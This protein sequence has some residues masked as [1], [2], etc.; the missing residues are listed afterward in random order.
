MIPSFEHGLIL[1]SKNPEYSRLNF[2]EDSTEFN[3]VFPHLTSSNWAFIPDDGPSECFLGFIKIEILE[4][5]SSWDEK[6]V[7][8][9]PL[10]VFLV[11]NV[12]YRFEVEWAIQISIIFQVDK[13]WFSH[14]VGRLFDELLRN[15]RINKLRRNYNY[16]R[17]G[18][19]WHPNLSFLGVFLLDTSSIQI[20]TLGLLGNTSCRF[21]ANS[22][23]DHV[24]SLIDHV[25]SLNDVDVLISLN[26]W[27]RRRILL[28]HCGCISLLVIND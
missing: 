2:I 19:W 13:E 11:W 9:L 16:N 21:I 15:L 3:V 23:E 12:G 26:M 27:L 24:T 1:F 28:L 17:N 4:K 22:I 5:H 7:I 14:Q 10:N 20:L 25:T 18:R 8:C 6:V